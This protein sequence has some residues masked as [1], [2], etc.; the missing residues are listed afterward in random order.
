M[1]AGDAWY[2][3]ADALT[4]YNTHM[5]ITR[6][7]GIGFGAL[8]LLRLAAPLLVLFMPQL[9]KKFQQMQVILDVSGG[10]IILLIAG[11][12]W[13]RGRP[14]IAIVLLLLGI[15]VFIGAYHALPAWWW[16]NEDQRHRPKGRR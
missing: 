3:R 5:M 2:N 9:R 10:L 1:S 12:L 13:W 15:P 6:L 16:G 11:S 4:R 8:L 14:E 7:L